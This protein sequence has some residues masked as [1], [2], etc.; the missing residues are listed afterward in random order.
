MN[1]NNNIGYFRANP[2]G[3]GF[4]SDDRGIGYFVAPQ[5][6]RCLLSG[7]LVKFRI[8]ESTRGPTAIDCQVLRRNPTLVGTVVINEAGLVD[9]RPEECVLP[10]LLV[11][12]L[13][14]SMEGKTVC[15]RV[16]ERG[17]F[18][19]VVHGV[20]DHIVGRPGELGYAT[21]H[22]CAKW[23]IPLGEPDE[24]VIRS[25]AVAALASPPLHL[26]VVTI[27]SETS[28]DFD[29]AVHARMTV[30]GFV[31]TVAIADVAAAVPLGSPVDAFARRRGTTVY[32]H[33]RVIPMLPAQLADD[34]CSLRPGVPRPALCVTIDYDFSGR[35]LKYELSRRT[36]V[37]AARLTYEQVSAHAQGLQRLPEPAAGTV[38]SLLAWHATVK[39]ARDR[40]GLLQFDDI[41]W[42]VE[43]TES[44][45]ALRAVPLTYAHQL[46]EDAMLAANRCAAAQ[47]ILNNQASLFRHHEGVSQHEWNQAL[48]WFESIGVSAPETPALDRLREFLAEAAKH[49]LWE[50]IQFRVRRCLTHATYDSWRASHFTLDFPAYTHFTS[51]IRRYA[52]LT[53][54]RMLLGEISGREGHEELAE[55]LSFV[56]RRAASATR[57]AA[58]RVKLA[59]ARRELQTGVATCDGQVVGSGSYGLRVHLPRWQVSATI[60]REELERAGFD[61]RETSRAWTRPDEVPLWPGLRITVSVQADTQTEGLK[62]SLPMVA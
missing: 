26:P 17:P 55:H 21:R 41:E 62:G 3:F 43:E 47:L 61:Y 11:S 35:I 34:Q 56:S 1:K 16:P 60:D 12:S 13:D 22:A 19:E 53:V 25:I 46:I 45:M 6:A 30:S 14:K 15:V 49:P 48:E 50:A 4:V 39:P 7:D 9:F 52:D 40:R 38:D 23:D 10:T 42:R 58:D 24:E 51:P 33:D 57:A 29:D 32:F 8:L 36:I 44:G 59:I 31:L 5:D 27:D 2:K 28:K 37:S 20:V 18:G 54:H